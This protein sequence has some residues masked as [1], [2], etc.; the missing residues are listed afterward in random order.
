M[1]R[2]TTFHRISFSVMRLLALIGLVIW[3]FP[4]SL[5]TSV[6]ASGPADVQP[7]ASALK[8]GQ[9]IRAQDGG[10]T[11][12]FLP[13]ITM[14][15]DD[16]ASAESNL[17]VSSVTAGYAHACA[18]RPDTSLICWGLDV[19]GQATPIPG[20]FTQV[21]AGAN[22]TCGIRP[23]GTL[24]CWGDNT[25][26]QSIA[27]AGTYSVVSAGGYH[28]CA[29]DTAGALSCWG[30]NGFGQ[31]DGIPT[32]VFTQV[33][34]G[35]LHT[36][37]LRDNGQLAC[38]GWDGDGQIGAPAGTFVQVTAGGSH[39][40]ALA[41][42]GSLNCWGA[43][44]S[45]QTDVPD[46]IYG[47]VGAG[48]YHTCALRA[49]G[50]QAGTIVCWGGNGFGQLDQIPE[51]TFQQISVG[52]QHTCGVRTTG[53]I[54]CWGWNRYGQSFPPSGVRIAAG[55]AH[56][57]AV[58]VDGTLTCWG[59][60][61]S[62]QAD[63]PAGAYTRV[64]AG[65]QNTCAVNTAGALVC[66]GANGVGQSSPPG[67]IFL[68]PSVGAQHACAL[69]LN[70]NISCWGDNG[71]GQATPP[72]GAF[73]Q[74]SA[75]GLH[76][77][78]VALDGALSCWGDNSAGQ[79]TA[80]SGSYTQVSA[81]GQHTCAI[82]NTGLLECW[83]SN[84]AGQSTVTAGTFSQVSA[85]NAHTC[86]IRADGSLLCWGDNSY[87]QTESPSG[88]Y[89]Q[90]SSGAQ[91]SCAVGLDG[92]V[93]CWG[94]RA[95]TPTISISPD[96]LPSGKQDEPYS[97]SFSASG[98]TPPHTFT[99]MSGDLPAG[100]E[101]SPEGL[102]SGAPTEHGTF[103]FTI[104]AADSA[105]PPF[106]GLAD[107]NLTIAPSADLT[108][109]EITAN[110]TG[111]LGKNGWYTSDVS[112]VWTVVDL[113]SMILSSTGCD[114]V[115]LAEDTS[116]VTLTCSATSSGGASTKSLTFKIDRTAPGGI[117]AT[118]DRSPNTN[119]WYTRPLTITFN[120]EDAVSGIDSCSTIDYSG[121]DGNP[122]SVTGACTDLAGNRSEAV[123]T[124]LYDATMPVLNPAVSPNPVYLNGDAT[125]APNASDAT[126]GLAESGCDALNTSSVG[127]K[128][129]RCYASDNAGN[130]L[131][132]SANYRVIYRFTGFLD[133][134]RSAPVINQAIAGQTIPLI[135][136][137]RDADNRPVT[138]LTIA[139]VSTRW[140]WFACPTNPEI[141][142]L[143]NSHAA[144]GLTNLGNGRYQYNWETSGNYQSSCKT[145]YLGLSEGADAEHQALFQFVR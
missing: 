77:C 88:V 25:Y 79:S 26:G 67:G 101:L 21:S 69:D 58:R 29:I 2:L 124:F 4:T 144:G 73:S 97:Q 50:E 90:V 134:V 31:L 62:G 8:D 115:T 19:S 54:A 32:G 14:G 110:I 125:A 92:A 78:S 81:G 9:A 89:T 71:A 44:S 38:W 140:E 122:A 16:L 59:E 123:F 86:A 40:C 20:V 23:D 91:H 15:R 117:S 46:G 37:A 18:I 99:V 47:Y 142:V 85:G 66:W 5:T 48:M 24:G 106:A 1:F 94:L 93:I 27:P 33:S 130:R 36:C 135:F 137:L 12:I 57:C 41:P 111:T 114:P 116:G 119:G 131:E 98:G 108:P 104:Q 70:G 138:N 42:D 39:S 107:Y 72:A 6:R 35:N 53:T 34:S 56:S 74:I 145:F 120:G 112:V 43:S 3:L 60:N 141:N 109:P 52:G 113:E 51:G 7:D 82:T 68:E 10:P 132:E 95:Q 143:P 80:P 28:T 83:G 11:Q 133:P 13:M 84:S 102:L 128:Q 139:Q 100:L 30:W 87:G 55:G 22:H 75:G 136:D 105:N 96:S 49:N 64:S 126:S 127:N 103:S 61:S 129:V 63:V 118:P 76:T 45:G 17:V 121:P 65:S